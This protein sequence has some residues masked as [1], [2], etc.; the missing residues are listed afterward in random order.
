MTDSK[1]I[2]CESEITLIIPASG[3]SKKYKL[4]GT[5][6]ALLEIEQMSGRGFYEIIENVRKG[7]LGFGEIV[8]IVCAGLR[9]AGETA[10]YD[11][12][13]E[14]I[15]RTGPGVVIADVDKFL[16]RTL[17]GGRDVGEILAA[18]GVDTTE[19]PSAAI[20]GSESQPSGGPNGSSGIQPQQPCSPELSSGT[21]PKA[22]TTPKKPRT[23]PS[24]KKT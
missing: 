15:F 1:T 22:E 9:A 11:T 20:L 14:M 12:V 6:Q 2:K 23:S 8:A 3:M 16:T 4:V 13:A 21:L 10:D 19:S 5:W 7:K 17:L 18:A 24:S